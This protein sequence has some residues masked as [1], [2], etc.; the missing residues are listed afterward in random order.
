MPRHQGPTN[1]CPRIVAAARRHFL[2]QGFRRVTMDDLAAELGMS[3]KTLYACF[4]SKTAL[5]EAVL[6]AKFRAIE[7][8]VEGIM[9]EHAA[10]FPM[11]LHRLFT[12][13]QRQTEEIQPPFLRDLQREAPEL[14]QVVET[15][16]RGLIRRTFGKL[17]TEGRRAGMIRK[18]V[19]V[20]L[21]V[22]ILLGATQA[23]VSPAK[24]TELGLTA[25]AGLAAVLKV[26]LQGVTTP[27]GRV[28]L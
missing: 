12:A 10:D 7:A 15:R 27:K 18:D 5:V 6:L 9:T 11:A 20:N 2:A 22:E 1:E 4:P 25:K 19:P 3:K 23:V 16:R 28:K 17:F 8:D 21:V 14:F 26:V 13:L 24:L